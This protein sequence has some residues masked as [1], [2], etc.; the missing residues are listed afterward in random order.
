MSD[1][2]NQGFRLEPVNLTPSLS[3]VTRTPRPSPSPSH[4]LPLI[5][6]ESNGRL[7]N[8][9]PSLT[10]SATLLLPS[11]NDG[12]PLLP[13]STPSPIYPTSTSHLFLRSKGLNPTSKYLNTL[14]PALVPTSSRQSSGSRNR[15]YMQTSI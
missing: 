10:P 4:H 5:N 14:S 7:V 9:S 2:E 11:P 1:P 6:D 8:R 15:L 13:F 12:S 3:H